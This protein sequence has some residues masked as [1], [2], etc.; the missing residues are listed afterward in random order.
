MYTAS[1]LK[2]IPHGFFTRQGGVSQGFFDSLNFVLTKGDNAEHVRQNREIALQHLG[3]QEKTLVT[4]NQVHGNKVI[5]VDQPWPFNEQ[6]TP[7][8]DA[9]VTQN[10]NL[11]LGI[12]TADCVPVLLYD[13]PTQTIG[14][15]HSGWRGAKAN[16]AS[17]T[18]KVLQELGANPQDI[19]A[20]IGPAIRQANYE[21][22]TEVYDAFKYAH[23]Q[24]FIPSTKPDHYLFDLPGLVMQQLATAGLT[25]I[26]DSKLNTYTKET[27]FFSCR[28]AFHKGEATFG[29]MLSAISLKV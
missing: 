24:Y 5:L 4:L 23:P 10:P 18:V 21:V 3:L 28:R 12:L 26:E 27:E 29:C 17:Q 13:D 16:I 14:A 7:D 20:V 9:L 2:S 8:A 1:S 22:S 15:I 6:Q 11:V 19:K 25:N